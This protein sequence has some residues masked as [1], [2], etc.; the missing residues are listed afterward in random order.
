VVITDDFNC[1]RFRG[2]QLTGHYES[3]FQRANH[4]TQPLGFWIRYTI[5]SPDR[6]PRDAIGELWAVVFDGRTGRHVAAKTE[7]PITQ[8]ALSNDRFNV[9]VGEAELGPGALSG[10]AG[11]AANNVTWKLVYSG[12]EAP[13]FDLPL[14]RYESG[15]PKAKLLVSVPMARF[16]GM[17]TLNGESLAVDAWIGSLNH[18]WGVRHTDRYAWGQVCGFDDAPDSFLEVA[19]AQ[20]KLGPLRSPLI[21]LVVVRHDG[22][23]Y[24]CNSFLQGIKARASYDYSTWRFSSRSNAVRIQ[25]ELRAPPAAFVGLRYRNPPGGI[26]YCINTKIAECSLS[27]TDFTTARTD[28]LRTATRA[29]FEILTDDTYHGFEMRT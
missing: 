16:T 15:F 23:E 9:R 27:I 12:G 20:L 14:D 8:C 5:F 11:S 26:K 24:A 21:T 19:S 13:V 7:V 28:T 2:G 17:I 10:R 22:K 4:P 18:N 6:R 29:G 3:Y 25:G 1:A